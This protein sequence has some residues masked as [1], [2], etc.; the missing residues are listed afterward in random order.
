M[1]ISSG[2]D[3]NLLFVVVYK[4]HRLDSARNYAG[5]LAQLVQTPWI[6][7]MIASDGI[8]GRKR[9]ATC[10]FGAGRP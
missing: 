6:L 1:Q 5:Y 9:S 7:P 2:G 3:G 4:P 8:S 10:T